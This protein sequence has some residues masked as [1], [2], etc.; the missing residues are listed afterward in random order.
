MRPNAAGCTS[1]LCV[2]WIGQ[3]T[4]SACDRPRAYDRRGIQHSGVRGRQSPP[5]R[6]PHPPP[7]SASRRAASTT[8]I[9]TTA[10][11]AICRRYS[12]ISM[13]A[14]GP[15][16]GESER[17]PGQGTPCSDKP[18]PSQIARGDA[19]SSHGTDVLVSSSRL[20]TRAKL[21]SM[22]A[23]RISSLSPSHQPIRTWPP[24]KGTLALTPR[25]IF[26]ISSPGPESARPFSP[27][28]PL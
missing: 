19:S 23:V 25:R 10:H 9:S 18:P 2:A 16:P 14:A 7:P 5:I 4:Q 28:P 3:A 1:R 22:A 26:N 27:D 24:S 6:L 21:N 12:V 8:G 11:K 15:R 20:P 13:L 17:R